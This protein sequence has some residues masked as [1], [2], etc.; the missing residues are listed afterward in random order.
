MGKLS[1]IFKPVGTVATPAA[2]PVWDYETGSYKVPESVTD[3]QM[4]QAAMPT[5]RPV[6]APT[7]TPAPAPAPT[8]TPA[9]APVYSPIYDA[10]VPKSVY[11]APAP[12][13]QAPA[14]NPPVA[15]TGMITIDPVEQMG[16][17]FIPATPQAAPSPVTTATAPA[18]PALPAGYSTVADLGYSPVVQQQ[19]AN[20]GFTSLPGYMKFSGKSSDQTDI[21]QQ[22]ANVMGMTSADIWDAWGREGAGKTH[23]AARQAINPFYSLSGKKRGYELSPEELESFRR[24]YMT[25]ASQENKGGFGLSEAAGLGAVLAPIAAAIAGPAL[26]GGGAATAATGGLGGATAAGAGETAALGTA[27]LAAGL[28]ASVGTAAALGSAPT[29]EAAWGL[30]GPSLGGSLEAAIANGLAAGADVGMG[31]GTSVLTDLGLPAVVGNDLGALAEYV[32]G[33]VPDILSGIDLGSLLGGLLPA[34]TAG[35]IPGLGGAGAGQ[36]IAGGTTS[37]PQTSP[38]PQQ[39]ILR[40]AAPIT[41]ATMPT[42]SIMGAFANK[43]GDTPDYLKYLSPLF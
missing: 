17:A 41:P 14:P 26:L 2:T 31:G 20:L 22:I 13:Y 27:A 40:P 23:S 4:T 16:K 7:P 42:G 33:Q 39:D 9:P 19:L 3:Q 10:L 35:L 29:M 18:A 34:L 28:P 6:P 37:A 43:S 30:L 11:Q 1:S 36:G 5:A 32:A 38:I 15:S 25:R 8:P 24:A 12:V 21:A